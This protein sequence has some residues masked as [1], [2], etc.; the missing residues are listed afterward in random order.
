MYWFYFYG[1][2]ELESL[3]T[4][5]RNQVV[6]AAFKGFRKEHPVDPVLRATL[7]L[8]IMVPA[9]LCGFFFAVEAALAMSVISFVLLHI[10]IAE[11]DSKL[12]CE[13]LH[14]HFNELVAL[15]TPTSLHHLKG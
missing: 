10:I 15:V 1:C 5:Q 7:I 14:Q 2:K 3:S 8:L 9:L 11:H 6:E 12:A 13:Y 4:D